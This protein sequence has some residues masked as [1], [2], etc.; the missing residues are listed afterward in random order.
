MR[1]ALAS[2]RPVPAGRIGWAESRSAGVPFTTQLVSLFAC[3][4]QLLDAVQNQAQP[5]LQ[6]LILLI[7]LR[8]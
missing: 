3:G 1:D 2:C 6:G 4:E 5:K 8:R 7:V